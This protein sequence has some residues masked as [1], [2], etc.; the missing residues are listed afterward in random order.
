MSS[1]IKSNR[2]ASSQVETPHKIVKGVWK[3]THKYKPNFSK[4]LDLGA[5][6]GKF[7]LGGKFKYYEGFE[8]DKRIKPFPKLPN[9]ANIKY[10]CAFKENSNGYDLCI[11]NPP[12]LRHH[13][14]E[15]LWRNKVAEKINQKLDISLN[16]RCNLFVYFIALGIIKTNKDGLISLVIP[17]EWVSRPSVSPLRDLIR[18]QGWEV[19]VYRFNEPIFGP[20]LTTAS[21]SIINKRQKNG[22]WN[23]FEINSNFKITPIKGILKSGQKVLQYENRSKIWALRGLSP[24]SQKIFCLTEGERIHFGLKP[25]DVNPCI[26][27]FKEIPEDFLILNKNKFKKYF[28]NSGKKCWLIKSNLKLSKRLELYLKNIPPEKRDTSTCK[29]QNPWYVYHPFPPPQVIY[30]SAFTKY[31]PKIF[32]NDVNAIT[33][34]SVHGIHA[35]Q[36]YSKRKLVDYLKKI[37]FEKQVVSHAGS[38]KKI[39]V[40]QMNGV[41]KTFLENDKKN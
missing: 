11:G 21:V 19:N 12:Y 40:R 4:V 38:L 2:F 1:L 9:N 28:I 7:I 39:E 26:T 24:G 32:I 13:E 18:N 6:D 35:D 23:Y 8:I 25:S 20:V 30:G 10:K 37:N 5:G 29:K 34:G 17:Y 36:I 27:S 33:L 22:K 14:V 41:L 15:D 3:L 16:K 31:R